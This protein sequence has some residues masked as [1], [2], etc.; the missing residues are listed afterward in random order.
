MGKYFL[1]HNGQDQQKFKICVRIINYLML[2]K[3]NRAI[4]LM[5]D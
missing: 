4:V 3:Q 2:K 1:S 5:E